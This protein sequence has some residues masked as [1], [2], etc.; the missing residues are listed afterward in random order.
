MT[1]TTNIR[2]HSHTGELAAGAALRGVALHHWLARG[3]RLA[4]AATR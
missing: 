3:Q 4:V 1:T 2:F